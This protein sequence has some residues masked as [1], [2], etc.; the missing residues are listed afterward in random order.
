MGPKHIDL[1]GNR[2]GKLVVLKFSHSNDGAYWM[3]QCHCGKIITR[4]GSEIKR[5]ERN[6]VLQ[7][8]GCRT[9]A[10]IS[11]ETEI[12]K[13]CPKCGNIFDVS[14]F[15][16]SK[17]SRSG[18]SAHCRLC[19]KKYREE[20]KSKLKNSKRNYYE[21]NKEQIAKYRA[22]QEF[23]NKNREGM[24]KRCKK[25][26]ENNKEKRRS[27]ANE[28]VKRNK[29]Y[30]CHIASKRR[31]RRLCAIPKWA[32]LFNI[33]QI[34]RLARLATAMIGVKYSVDHVVPLVNESVCGLHCEANLKIVKL[35]D[36]I[37]KNNR[38][39]PDMP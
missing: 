25:Y 13:E 22:T 16:L 7:S 26:I 35:I 3:C 2:Y 6:K 29:S 20:N 21:K 23:K 11:S 15:T 28:W 5:R 9:S 33:A 32:N 10:I 17:E 1:T 14:M 39:W 31:A 38:F 34:Y 37:S 36:N 18:Y 30:A 8:C 24:I 4:K 19:T 12:K 27:V